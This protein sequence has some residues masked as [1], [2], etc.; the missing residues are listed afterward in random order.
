MKD[1]HRARLISLVISALLAAGCA[2]E[3]PQVAERSAPAEV[4]VVNIS[5]SPATLRIASGT[6]VVWTNQDEGVHHTVTSGL[7]GD[8]GVPGV[9][10][11]KPPSTDGVFNGD[12]PDVSS[13]FAFTFS[14]P[15]TYAY[16]CRVHPSMTAQVIVG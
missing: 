4:E 9:A 8:N 11:P 2:S 14:S 12:L 10:E 13:Q 16:F 5:F 1:L 3:D 6:E 15:G 7:P